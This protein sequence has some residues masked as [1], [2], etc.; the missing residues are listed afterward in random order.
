MHNIKDSEKKTIRCNTVSCRLQIVTNIKIICEIITL[1]TFD[2]ALP[3]PAYIKDV[4]R[5]SKTDNVKPWISYHIPKENNEH[6]V[7]FLVIKLDN[8]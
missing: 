3:V 5:T 1:G 2:A 7:A 4:H 8:K 6:E